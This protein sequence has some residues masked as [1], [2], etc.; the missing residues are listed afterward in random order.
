[1][2]DLLHLIVMEV[3]MIDCFEDLFMLII[4]LGE[5]VY[6]SWRDRVIEA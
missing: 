5:R 3:K 1:M 6:S 2:L 4:G